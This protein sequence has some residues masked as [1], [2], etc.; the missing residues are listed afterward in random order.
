MLTF[1]SEQIFTFLCYLRHEIRWSFLLIMANLLVNIYNLSIL[2]ERHVVSI[3]SHVG[4][5]T[6]IF[7]RL[8]AVSGDE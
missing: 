3:M 7:D 8:L 2:V 1:V 4:S 5:I 6:I